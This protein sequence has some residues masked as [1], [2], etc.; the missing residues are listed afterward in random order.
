VRNAT[1]ATT[2][3]YEL[4]VNKIRRLNTTVQHEVACFIHQ[5]LELVNL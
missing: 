4:L 1:A 3:F 2:L 5:N